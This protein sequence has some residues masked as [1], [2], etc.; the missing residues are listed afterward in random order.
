MLIEP[1]GFV[2]NTRHS[3]EDDYW[4]GIVSEIVINESLGAE[5]IQ[6]IEDFSHTE[7]IF[8]FHLVD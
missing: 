8:A 6:G 7:V 1:I 5:A 4:G 3:V 2:K